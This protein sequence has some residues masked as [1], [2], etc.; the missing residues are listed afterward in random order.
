MSIV[1]EEEQGRKAEISLRF[2]EF[3]IPPIQDVLLVGRRAPVG[4]NAV[5]RM[6]DVMSPEQYDI[7]GVED[8]PIEAVVI[9]KSLL[10]ILPRDKLLPLILDEGK[11]IADESSI[12]KAQVEISILIKR[13]VEL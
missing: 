4:P 12:I 8:G 13:T 7:I 10:N 11:R 3:E 5:R 6:V 9:R 1:C 2:S